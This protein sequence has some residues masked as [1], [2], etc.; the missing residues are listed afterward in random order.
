MSGTIAGHSMP[1]SPF[2]ISQ[3]CRHSRHVWLKKIKFEHDLVIGKDFDELPKHFR[4]SI[5]IHTLIES[6]YLLDT[7]FVPK[8][9]L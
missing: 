4:Q 2:Q 8:V 1:K 5:E 9:L 3:T 6:L 7:K